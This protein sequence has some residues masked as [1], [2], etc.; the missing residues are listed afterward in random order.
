MNTFISPVFLPNSMKNV[1][2]KNVDSLRF[3]AMFG[4]IGQHCNIFPFGWVGVWLFFVISG[5][6]VTESL[7]RT[8]LTYKVK[9]LGG[10]YN[11]RVF[12]IVPLYYIFCLI[13]L[14]FF[15]VN[16]AALSSNQATS[17]LLFYF[18]YLALYSDQ[19]RPEFP[20]T[21]LWSISSE[22]QFYALFGFLFVLL[23]RTA[24]KRV[25]VICIVAVFVLRIVFANLH[26]SA[27]FPAYDYQLTINHSFSF[28]AFAVGILLSLFGHQIASRQAVALFFSGIIASLLFFAVYAAVN[29]LHL[30]RHGLDIFKD[31]AS[32]ANVGQYREVMIYTPILLVSAGL[33]ACAARDTVVSRILMLRLPLM[34][35]AG[36]TSYSGYIW[37]FAVIVT[38]RNM[39]MPFAA[40]YISGSALAL[41]L[42]TFVLSV[43][44]TVVVAELSFRFIE[45]PLNIYSRLKAPPAE[46]VSSG[47][48]I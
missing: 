43:P 13:V 24:L 39:M 35:R 46:V 5:F 34:Q 48:V 42:I 8:D 30:G 33:V 37:H 10:F 38:V 23:S 16:G 3:L 29:A 32:G 21:H 7:A 19:W 47:R 26:Y 40:T 14:V 12:R 1:R 28:D 25:L 4:V 6:V 36:K 22:M 18:N 9:S 45:V 41:D 15:A 11:R 20:F 27:W 2:Y 44:L 31:I 17:L